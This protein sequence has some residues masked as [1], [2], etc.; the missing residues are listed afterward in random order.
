M[1]FEKVFQMFPDF[2]LIKGKKGLEEGT[3]RQMHDSGR[4]GEMRP[5]SGA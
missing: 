2:Q 4:Q 5:G 1:G 3:A